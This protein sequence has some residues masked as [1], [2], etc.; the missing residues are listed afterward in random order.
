MSRPFPIWHAPLNWAGWRR[1]RK[2]EPVCYDCTFSL[3]YHPPSCLMFLPP[4]FSFFTFLYW[5]LHPKKLP[6]ERFTCTLKEKKKQRKR[7]LGL[8]VWFSTISFILSFSLWIK[9]KQIKSTWA[10]HQINHKKKETRATNLSRG[11][12]SFLRMLTMCSLDICYHWHLT[13]WSKKK[14]KT[15]NWIDGAIF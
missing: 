12:W 4:T 2:N 9:A 3:A 8:L 11:L 7:S 15:L 6:L 5:K 14:R 10:N 13:L 1:E